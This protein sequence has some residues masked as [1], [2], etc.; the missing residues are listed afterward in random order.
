M[1]VFH[2]ILTPMDS[3]C[4]RDAGE[5]DAKFE[6]KG[7]H[8]EGYAKK[9]T[10]DC[11]V[12]LTSEELA[13]TDE[14][15]DQNG[16]LTIE[17]VRE[18]LRRETIKETLEM[19]GE[20]CA[21][22]AEIMVFVDTRIDFQVFVT[23]ENVY[24]REEL[25]EHFPFREL[26]TTPEEVFSRQVVGAFPSRG[27]EGAYEYAACDEDN[28]DGF[29][30]YTQEHRHNSSTRGW[31]GPNT[32]RVPVEIAKTKIYIGKSRWTD[33]L[34][35]KQFIRSF[36]TFVVPMIQ[37]AR[38]GDPL[39]S[40]ALTHLL[41]GV[42]GRPAIAVAAGDSPPKQQQALSGGDGDKP[43]LSRP[44]V[45]DENTP[46]AGKKQDPLLGSGACSGGGEW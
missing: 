44:P 46:G 29:L 35:M 28:E 20:P 23:S 1:K 2:P 15:L 30:A 10:A 8:P 32:K 12:F 43:P 41:G 16:F 11:R 14:Y 39:S 19:R 37:A 25:E 4:Y 3:C 24:T 40:R 45:G 33:F 5:E 13:R 31:G 26:R 36:Q 42:G 34:A 22:E 9:S 27:G 38:D 17:Q 6:G 21:I 7:A 18:L